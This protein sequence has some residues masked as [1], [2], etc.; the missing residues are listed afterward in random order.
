MR[1]PVVLCFRCSGNIILPPEKDKIYP[2]RETTTALLPVPQALE[3]EVEG[4]HAALE[5]APEASFASELPL[6]VDDLPWAD[7]HQAN[8]GSIA[9]RHPHLKKHATC[10]K[11]RTEAIRIPMRSR[12]TTTT[13]KKL[14]QPWRCFF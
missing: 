4:E 10:V 8:K 13:T 3:V 2:H 6:P 9:S 12:I 7:M 14:Y 1:P 5:H 11:R